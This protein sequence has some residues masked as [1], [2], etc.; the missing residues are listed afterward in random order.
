MRFLYFDNEYG[1]MTNGMELNVTS[2]LLYN[3]GVMLAYVRP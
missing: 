1:E 3:E 2:F